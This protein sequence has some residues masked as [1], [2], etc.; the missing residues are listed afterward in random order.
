M[1]TEVSKSLYQADVV[2]AVLYKYLNENIHVEENEFY[3][4]F[5]LS[6]TSAKADVLKQKILD[7]ILDEQLRYD[8]ESKVGKVR[9]LIVEHAFKPIT[10]LKQ[11]IDNRAI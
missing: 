3:W 7:D 9:E 6:V 2:R 4:I 10:N 5:N 1:K 8:L 11:E